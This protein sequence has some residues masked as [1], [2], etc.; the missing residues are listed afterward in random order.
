MELDDA[1]EAYVLAHTEP[2][3]DLLKALS[4]ETGQKVLY[5]NMLSG[6]LQG[7][8]LSM[9]SRMVRPRRILEIGTFT[10]YSALCLAEGLA[11]DGVLHTVD[12]NDEL[13]WLRQKYFKQSACAEAIHQHLGDGLALAGSLE[14]P[15]DLVFVDAD[16]GRYPDYF[17][18]LVPRMPKGSWLVFDNV[19]WYGK[20]T[21]TLKHKDKETVALDALNKRIASDHRVRPLILPIRDG[22]T[23]CEIV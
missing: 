12:I 13:E 16:K 11:P 22:L 5:K 19:L 15:F 1:L 10:G 3:S 23:V 17:E 18:V 14:G 7:R 20:V 2:E 6:H 9:V 21:N 4:R 8:L